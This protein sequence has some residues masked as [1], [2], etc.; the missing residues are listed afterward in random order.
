MGIL[1][2]LGGGAGGIIEGVGKI[3]DDVTTSDEERAVAQRLLEELRQKPYLAQIHLNA[4][5]ANHRSIF[6]AGWR[7]FAGWVCGF[8]LG[9]AYLFQPFIIAIAVFFGA[10]QETVDI[11]PKIDISVMIPILVSM[12]GLGALRST[13]KR[14]G[15]TQN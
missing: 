12:L 10:T 5:E 15:V 6:I 4:Q 13:D 1:N 9:Y 2:I 7:P 11:I 8:A 3:L 14:N